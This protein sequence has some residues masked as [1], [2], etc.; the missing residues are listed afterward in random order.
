[1]SNSPGKEGGAICR[2]NYKPE[3]QALDLEEGVTA[4]S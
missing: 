3:A 1:M 4:G 2:K